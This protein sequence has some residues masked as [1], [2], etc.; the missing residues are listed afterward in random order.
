MQLRDYQQEAINA[1]FSYFERARGNPLLVLPTGAGKSVIQAFFLKQVFASWPHQRVICLTHVKEL[2]EQNYSKLIAVAPSLPV[3]IFSASLNRRDSRQPITF[4]GIQSVYKRAEQFGHTDLI[5]VDECH[6]I[7]KKGTGMYISF[8]EALQKINPKLK[9]IGMSATPFRLDSGFLH[10][11]DGALFTDLAYNLP[12]T[13]L[14]QE[15]HLCPVT[16]RGSKHKIDLSNVKKSGGE[17]ILKEMDVEAQKITSAAV[18]EIMSYGHDRKAWL[19]FC[20]SINHAEIVKNLLVEYGINAECVHSRLKKNERARILNDF[21]AGKIKAITNID[22]LT[23]GFD[24]PIL[25]TIIYLRGTESGSLY[26]QMTGRGMR[27]APDKNDCLILD[28]AGNVTRHGPIDAVKIKVKGTSGDAEPALKECPECFQHVST[29]AQVC[30]HCGAQLVD[31]SP[32]VPQH[33]ATASDAAILSSEIE[34]ESV[35][36]DSMLFRR[37]KKEGK[38]DSVRVSYQCGIAIFNTWVCVE[39]GGYARDNA[40]MWLRQHLPDGDIP[41]TTAD[42]LEMGNAG[43]FLTPV[44]ITIKQAGQYPEIIDYDFQLPIKEAI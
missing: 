36:C 7:P 17:Y 26:I 6:L 12:I 13:R 38:P 31:D 29:F 19:I 33:D 43:A 34:P 25:D 24:C 10:E 16:T 23:T 4:A 28:F 22:V 44:S 8:I 11:G 41:H 5:I 20:T 39:H 15:G 30:P 27:C 3:G 9:V 1:L 37:H 18:E 32:V 35:I 14:L 2:I 42:I 40:Y 21:K